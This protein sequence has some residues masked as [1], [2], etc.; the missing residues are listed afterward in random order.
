[1]AD[2]IVGLGLVLVIEGLIYALF[3]G[4]VRR[5]AMEVPNLPDS[6]LRTFGLLALIA[7]VGIVW[8][9]RG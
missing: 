8:L 7:G 9:V 4:G 6:V 5:M 1:M 3:P 2:L